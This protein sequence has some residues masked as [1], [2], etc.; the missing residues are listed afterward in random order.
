MVARTV[1]NFD[2]IWSTVGNVK[3]L[4]IASALIALLLPQLAAGQQTQVDVTLTPDGQRLTS[5]LGITEPELIS[6]IQDSVSG[7]YGLTDTHRLLTHTAD[8]QSL[9]NRGLGVDYASNPDIFVVGF[10]VAATRS[11]DNTYPVEGKKERYDMALP[12]E[13]AQVGLMAGMNL[14]K[15]KHLWGFD[16]PLTLSLNL[17]SFTVDPPAQDWKVKTRTFGVHAQYQVLP[18]VGTNWVFKWG[19]LF[20][21]TGYE[22]SLL[23]FN[24]KGT[25]DY[26]TPLGYRLGTEDITLKTKSTGDAEIAQVAKTIPLEVSSNITVAYFLT[27]YGVLGVDFQFGE[28]RLRANLDSDIYTDEELTATAKIIT[29]QSEKATTVVGHGVFGFQFNISVVKIYGQIALATSS[30]WALASG[31]RIAY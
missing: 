9:A 31:M 15:L 16:L 1:F 22:Y 13:G 7:L 28:A 24:I 17:L 10:G 23:Q 4:A 27:L 26:D 14:N 29:S 5:M 12:V 6:R 30:E 18:G 2:Q 21:T 11:V 25:L 19:G 20:V 3:R 8:A